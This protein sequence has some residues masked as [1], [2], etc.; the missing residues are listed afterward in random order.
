MHRYIVKSHQKDVTNYRGLIVPSRG[1]CTL[2]IQ[3]QLIFR[4]LQLKNGGLKPGC[5][6]EDGPMEQ[7]ALTMTVLGCGD[8]A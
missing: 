4:Y 7:L 6:S 5:S 8:S 1:F 2:H 3:H